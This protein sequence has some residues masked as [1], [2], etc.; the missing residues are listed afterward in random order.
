MKQTKAQEE[1]KKVIE[2]FQ[3]GEIGEYIAHSYFPIPNIPCSK[4]SLKNRIIMSIN[5]TSDARGFVQWKQIG[6]KVKKGSKAFYILGPV[7]RKIKTVDERTDE[8]KESSMVVGFTSIPV[9][10]V[11]DTEGDSLDYEVPDLPDFPLLDVAYKFGLE[12]KTG[13]FTGAVFGYYSSK[14]KL[15]QLN[16]KE[17]IVFFHEL[18]HA[19]HDRIY[20]L[21]SLPK[22]YKE[23]V[24]ELTAVVLGRMYGLTWEKISGLSYT[25][26]ESYARKAKKSPVKAC[27]EVID[28]IEKILN[29]IFE[30][31]EALKK[32]A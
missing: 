12:V 25:Y 20:N 26:I 18:A 9:F 15:I 17:E 4:W 5:G 2:L 19:A 14:R 30:T 6:R 13:F 16:T 29:L 28:D 10:K 27:L 11:E 22:W 21:R 31:E 24:A 8:E 32:V 23:V 3:K 7:K 1:L